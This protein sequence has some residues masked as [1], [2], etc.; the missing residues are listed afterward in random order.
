M[1]PD[2]SASISPAFALPG[3][4][5]PPAGV[6]DEMQGAD[7][8][9]RAHWRPLLGQ[10]EAMGP[11]Q[12][13]FARDF[14]ARQLKDRGVFYRVYGDAP[15]ADR[16]W[17][18]S[19]APMILP[20]AEWAGL[21]G[22]LIQRAELL[23]RLAAD[24]YGEA[25]TVR[26]GLLPAA[27]IASDPDFLRPMVGAQPRGGRHLR[28]Y[29]V[30]L[31]RGPDGRW[32][33][34]SDRTQAPS[35]AGYALE[36][37]II[38]S[39]SLASQYR[40]ANVHRLARFFQGEKDALNALGQTATTSL[41]RTITDAG[42]SES[43]SARACLLTPGPYNETYYEHSYL[44]RYLGLLLV[45]GA[46]LTVIDDV[47]YLKTTRG[48]S[49]VDVL[50]RRLDSD[51]A[52][53]LELNTASQLG[54]P[55][56]VRAV[57]AG[58]VAITNA[59][60]SGLLEAP[61]LKGFLPGLAEHLL[62]EPLQLD[63]LATWWC[64]EPAGR[65]QVLER[66]EGVAIRRTHGAMRAH[67][68]DDDPAL[69]ALFQNRQI[70]GGDLS[71]D[72]RDLLRSAI[73]AH[74]EEFLAQEI[75]SL[76]T[77]PVWQD[78]GLVPRACVLRAFISAAAD[79]SWRV[80]PG[81]FCRIADHADAR[82]VSMQSGSQSAD[83]WVLSDG[84]V[85][86]QSLLPASGQRLPIRRN[87]STLPSRTADHLYWLGRYVERLE[88]ALRLARAALDRS[89]EPQWA[90]A[91]TR[92]GIAG[93]LV[94]F[95]AI[96]APE[97]AAGVEDIAR[98]TL[99]QGSGG[100][101]ALAASIRNSTSVVRERLSPDAW[102]ILDALFNLL[103]APGQRAQ[104]LAGEQDVIGEGLRL[105][106]AFAGL[107]SENMVRL[108]GWRFLV[109]GKRLERALLT[110]RMVR[111]FLDAHAQAESAPEAEAVRLAPDA[112]DALLELADSQISYRQRYVLAPTFAPVVDLVVLDPGN[113]RAVAF[114]VSQI[115]D[116]LAELPR[117]QDNLLPQPTERLATR[118]WADLHGQ[119]AETLESDF[120]ATV[121]RALMQIS[122]A[123]SL[124]Y[125]AA[126]PVVSAQ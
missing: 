32:W 115:R 16:P 122:D 117:L 111:T 66:L 6:Y 51:F 120:L 17:P 14:A 78:G 58:N 1:L 88:H 10:F 95:G 107:V 89:A 15:G 125:F 37:R 57:H 102:S 26:S 73:E 30:D 121:E 8:Q 7:G 110:S 61:A 47:V 65:A 2:V 112:L 103:V 60:G 59:L 82:A 42:G 62:G 12:I 3:S 70:I 99:A 18:M 13:D 71:A 22:G 52:D 74:P 113:P 98:Q 119:Q 44:A 45:E 79:G 50:V 77:M 68:N 124:E 126:S 116:I 36:N 86:Q 4:Y 91:E 33:V 69:A 123:L 97:D 90:V 93:C 94:A 41:T 53:P 20:A 29:A 35:G 104:T 21:E 56:L 43:R 109:A 63:H 55:G 75:V 38:M 24:L 28:N 27:L 25:S 31:G 39:R 48:L 84:P 105:V 85:G 118:L 83:V 108:S 76:S 40:S 96:S 46:D 81:G 106:A 5:A 34:L 87:A 23:D 80:M 49:R 19:L 72:E 114:Q 92:S 100:L 67:L 54:V 11:P 9:V 64:G 101:P